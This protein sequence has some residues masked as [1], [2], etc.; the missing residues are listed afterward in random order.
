M[1]TYYPHG[2][3]KRTSISRVDLL[4]CFNRIPV[5]LANV[6]NAEPAPPASNLYALPTP[7]TSAKYSL[8]S[9]FCLT[10]NFK[11]RGNAQH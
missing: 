9:D 4:A 7:L 1:G 11:K 3:G 8:I 10:V 6:N 5:L 2:A